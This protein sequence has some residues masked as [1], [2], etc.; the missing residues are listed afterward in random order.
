MGDGRSAARIVRTGSMAGVSS[1]AESRADG[2]DVAFTF[3]TRTL[4]GTPVNDLADQ[5]SAAI[6]SGALD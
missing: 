4:F 1:R 5:L 6:T 2:I 3:N